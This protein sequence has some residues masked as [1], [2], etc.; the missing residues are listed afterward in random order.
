MKT[1]MILTVL[2]TVLGA[3]I[4]WSAPGLNTADTTSA[5]QKILYYTCPMHPSVKSDKPGGCPI[6]GMHLVPVYGKPAGAATNAPPTAAGT[7]TV[8]L[9]TPGCCSSGGC[10]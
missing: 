7:N 5:G 4:L 9:N 10:H 3:A 1:K 2:A 6:C 8:R